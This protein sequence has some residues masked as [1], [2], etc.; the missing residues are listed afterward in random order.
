MAD[1]RLRK[2]QRNYEQ[3]PS[4]SNYA[5]Y[6]R[7]GVYLGSRIS[8]DEW[9]HYLKKLNEALYQTLRSSRTSDSYRGFQ[10]QYGGY[11]VGLE[12]EERPRNPWLYVRLYRGDYT[13]ILRIEIKGSRLLWNLWAPEP[14]DSSGSSGDLFFEY[15]FHRTPPYTHAEELLQY[16]VEEVAPRIEQFTERQGYQHFKWYRRNAE[17]GP[18]PARGVPEHLNFKGGRKTVCT[19][20]VLAAFGIDACTYHYSGFLSQRLAILRKNGWAARSRNSHLK[21]VNKRLRFPAGTKSVGQARKIIAQINRDAPDINKWGDPIG[22][23]YMIRVEKHALLLDYDGRTIVDTDP[24][25]RD[26]R[27]VLDIRAVFPMPN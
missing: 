23:R 6:L 9:A 15:G 13:A 21:R 5:A 1:Y 27:K 3:E 7:A 22:T 20:H 16:L 10:A 14:G 19:S 11:Q 4:L 25:V 12:F 24:R 18:R 8:S 17:E 2:L 26:R